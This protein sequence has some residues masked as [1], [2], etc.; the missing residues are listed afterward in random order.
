MKPLTLTGLAVAILFFGL[1]PLSFAQDEKPSPSPN[2]K[3]EQIVQRALKVVGGDRYLQAKTVIGRGFFTE[4]RDG[5]SGIP[6]KFVDYISYPDKE[7]TEFTG[8][9]ARTIQTNFRDGGWI[10]D[11]AALTLK[12]QTPQQLEEFKIVTRVTVE[13]LLRGWGRANGATLSYVGRREAG[14][15]RRNE[16]LRLTYLDGFWVEYEFSAD[17][18]VPAK[19]IYQ[20]KQKNRDTEEIETIKEEDRLHKLITID[21]LTAPFIIDHYRNGTQTSRI[22]YETVEYNKPIADSLFSKPRDIKAIK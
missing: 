9:G 17:D 21:G 15:G 22:A 6:I 1:A 14:I 2:D 8:G 18:G 3:A 13:N 20:R 11:G 5:A 12:D 16:V 7:R 19:V 4:Y 10:Y